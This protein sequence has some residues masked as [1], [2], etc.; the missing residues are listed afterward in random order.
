MGGPISK[1]DAL[2][3]VII[4]AGKVLSIDAWDF[5]QVPPLP[6]SDR[7]VSLEDVVKNTSTESEETYAEFASASQSQP[8]DDEWYSKIVPDAILA[9]GLFSF[10]KRIVLY[11]P[12][13]GIFVLYLVFTI[14]LKRRKLVESMM[15]DRDRNMDPIPSRMQ[16][17]RIGRSLNLD[18]TDSTYDRLGG[19]DAVR[20]QLCIAALCEYMVQNVDVAGIEGKDPY[21]TAKGSCHNPTFNYY[22]AAAR[23]ALETYSVPKTSREYFVK[24]M[25]GPMERIEKLYKS[26][27]SPATARKPSN[28]TGLSTVNELNCILWTAA[29]VAEIRALDAL[30]RVL[31]ERLLT[32]AMRLSRKKNLRAIKL[33]WYENNY[34]RTWFRR[35]IKRKTLRDDRRN[36]QLTSAALKREMERLGNVQKNLLSRP[37]DLS[38]TSLL[39]ASSRTVDNI[40][41]NDELNDTNTTRSIADCAGQ[42]DSNW[43]RYVLVS[44]GSSTENVD[45]S[46][47]ATE[48]KKW[49]KKT[50]ELIYDLV[51]E[52]VAVEK[53][54]QKI[55][56]P[57]SYNLRVLSKW[58]E[59]DTNGDRCGWGTVLSMGKCFKSLQQ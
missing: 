51:I 2:L 35:I 41:G 28:K 44:V 56:S 50:R 53:T 21:L 5:F 33:G 54:Q 29:K 55:D 14:L 57:L 15:V 17:Q 18:S 23:E 13:V 48:A 32:S 24:M 19:V 4:L 45:C 25:V 30:L 20:S 49:T 1:F 40:L 58:K 27:F 42:I 7:K 11:K 26:P 36:F 22:A 6:D 16:R 46:D 43:A 52:T 9:N 8:R 39:M 38:E 3:L 10:L 34:R 37:E 47:W 59:Y 12:P 31:R